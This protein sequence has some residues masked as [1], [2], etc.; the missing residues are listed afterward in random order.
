M[1]FYKKTRKTGPMRFQCL[2]RLEKMYP[3]TPIQKPLMDKILVM[4]NICYG[5]KFKQNQYNK[6]YI[7]KY[8]SKEREKK[9]HNQVNVNKILRLGSYENRTPSATIN[10]NYLFIH[11]CS[12]HQSFSYEEWSNREMHISNKYNDCTSQLKITKLRGY[13]W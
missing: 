7:K 13:I 8:N 5:I 4:M 6:V 1:F 3:P 12:L 10:E 11:N 2:A 9:G